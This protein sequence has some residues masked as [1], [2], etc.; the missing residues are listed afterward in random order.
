MAADLGLAVVLWVEH[1]VTPRARSSSN[2]TIRGSPVRHQL[3]SGN[4]RPSPPLLIV[5][6]GLL[7]LVSI[8]VS[9]REITDRVGLFHL[10]A[11]AL[12]GII[13]VFLSLDLF[14]FYFFW[15]L[16]LIPMYFLIG[17]WGHEN[18]VTPRSSSSC[19]RSSAAC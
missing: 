16:M 8:A 1:P 9:W 6:T 10:A 2:R 5:L 17:L 7:G 14:L 15:E 19:S 3:S 12:A 11:V 18:R 13:G 4:R